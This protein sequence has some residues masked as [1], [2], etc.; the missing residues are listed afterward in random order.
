ML[1]HPTL[2]HPDGTLILFHLQSTIDFILHCQAEV[3]RS[4]EIRHGRAAESDE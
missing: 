2:R 4:K 3:R 1:T